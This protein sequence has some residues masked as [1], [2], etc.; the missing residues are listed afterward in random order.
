MEEVKIL[1]DGRNKKDRYSSYATH[2][3]QASDSSRAILNGASR[4]TSQLEPSAELPYKS[5]F[6]K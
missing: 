3:K 1:K 5:I 6:Q 2:Q 4:S